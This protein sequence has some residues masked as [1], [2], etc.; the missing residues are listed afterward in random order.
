MSAN[1]ELFIGLMS[2]T[3]LDGVD[4]ALVAFS[5][6]MPRVVATHY[7]P[8]PEAIR[9]S[10]LALQQPA[11]NELHD[12]A[13]L[14]QA[15][16]RLYARSVA[17]LLLHAGQSAQSVR[18]IGCHGQTIRH[19]PG[20]GYSIQLNQP[21]LLAEQTGISVV[22]D[23][24]SR[25]IA[26][27]GHGAPLV[28]AFHEAVFRDEAKRRVIVNIGGIA[29]LTDLSP[30]KPTGGFDCGPGNMLMDAWIAEHT[31]ERFD[32]GG[33]WARSG[34]VIPKLLEALHGHPFFSKTPPKSCG[35]EEFNLDFL[36]ANLQGDERAEDVQ[37]T[38]LELTAMGIAGSIGSAPSRGGEIFLCGGGAHNT[39]L[40]ERISELTQAYAVKKTDDCGIGADWVEAI[41]FAWLARQCLQCAP[42]NLP[43][44]TGA[45][46]RRIL[47]AIYQA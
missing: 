33:A 36:R 44:V 17:E 47:G 14:S 24:R 28:P 37:R 27:G 31:G 38:L 20:E 5:H 10:A 6:D 1:E 9:Q 35:R 18:A 29:N 15:L 21:A 23:F 39:L 12:A 7:L 8:Y 40:M 3:S 41:A 11:K 16:A 19:Q 30:G 45:T 42:G 2:G 13:M 4:A 25:D 32:Q 43:Q 34:R 46:G 22:A 26:A